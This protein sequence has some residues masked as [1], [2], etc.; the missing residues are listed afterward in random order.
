[1][2]Q[3][4]EQADRRARAGNIQ[5]LG[6][7]GAVAAHLAGIHR[8]RAFLHMGRGNV[9]HA[10]TTPLSARSWSIETMSATISSFGALYSLASSLAMSSTERAPSQSFKTPTAISSGSNTRSGA[11]TSH[12]PRPAWCRSLMCG[13]SAGRV[14]AV[15][16]ARV[17]VIASPILGLG[18]EG[19]G[20]N[21]ALD[22]GMLE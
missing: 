19:S 8:H 6:S 9:V 3:L 10:F 11:N 18:P 4:R 13:G 15:T 14:A 5:R 12:L 22:V 20:R 1:M 17:R 16:M 7:G 2:G 21:V